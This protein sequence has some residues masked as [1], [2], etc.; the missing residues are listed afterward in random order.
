VLTPRDVLAELDCVA[1]AGLHGLA[2]LALIID[3]AQV[4]WLLF[5]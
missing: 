4:L 2:A 3:L 1:Y 5:W